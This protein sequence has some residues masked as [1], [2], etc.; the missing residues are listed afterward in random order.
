[1]MSRIL[2]VVAAILLV[3]AV[4]VAI[5]GPPGLP[6]GRAI[7]LLDQGL[8]SALHGGI[9]AYAGTWLWDDVLQ[10]LLVRPAWLVPASIGLIFA[11]ASVTV[12]S[13]AGRG[14]HRRPGSPKRWF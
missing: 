8:L 11:G 6:L 12:G 3:G 2:A 7:S 13:R 10:P 4:G 1:M 5:L 14:P 9:R